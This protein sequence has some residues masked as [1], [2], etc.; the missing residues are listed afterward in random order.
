MCAMVV[1]PNAE[2]E[3]QRRVS[4]ERERLVNERAALTNRINGLLLN[5]GI[6]GYA[7]LKRDRCVRLAALRTGDGRPLPPLAAEISRLLDRLEEECDALLAE[8]AAAYPRSPFALLPTLCETGTE[9]ATGLALECFTHGFANRGQV[10]LF[11]GLPPTPWRSGG[12]QRQQGIS[13]AERLRELMIEGRLVVA[14][15]SAERCAEPVV[16]YQGRQ[17]QGASQAKR[18]RPFLRNRNSSHANAPLDHKSLPRV[19]SALGYITVASSR[20]IASGRRWSSTKRCGIPSSAGSIRADR[21]PSS[22]G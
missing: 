14:A 16:P 22:W 10:A 21:W 8:L 1:R 4:R 15:L 2:E 5:Y 6:V 13:T 7:P 12:I 18:P 20:V 3:D 11:V 19:L 17:R 9:V